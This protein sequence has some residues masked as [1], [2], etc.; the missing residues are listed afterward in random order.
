MTVSIAMAVY[1]GMRFLERQMQSLLAQSLQPDEVIICDDASTDGTAEFVDNFIKEHQLSTWRLSVNACN[2]GFREN[3]YRA[4]SETTGDL[5][6]LCDQDDIWHADKLKRMVSVMAGHPGIRSLGCGYRLIDEDGA[7]KQAAGD[8]GTFSCLIPFAVPKG[9]LV[10]IGHFGDDDIFMLSSNRLLGCTMLI[11][12]RTAQSYLKFSRRRIA[13]DWEMN[14]I[15]AI[16]DGLYFLNEP[17]VEYRM[18]DSNTLGLP[19]LT[20]KKKKRAP[21]ILGRREIHEFFEAAVEFS[22]AYLSEMGSAALPVSYTEYARVRRSVLWDRS[23]IAL[24]RLWCIYH[25]EY[26]RLFTFEQR[27][28]DVL[29]VALK[30]LYR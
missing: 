26:K 18:H 10:N 23:F 28:G 30:F 15:A 12:R 19:N 21:D 5:I 4:V 6:A 2:V 25:S 27:L 1:Q 14:L 24:V 17:L 29:I 11:D 8:G 7:P 20:Q 16:E 13:H 22:N 9:A 3:F